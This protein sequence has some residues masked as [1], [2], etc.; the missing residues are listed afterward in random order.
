MKLFVAN[1]K[2]N[3]TLLEIEEYI[4]RLED[5]NTNNVKLVICPSYPYL[6]LFNGNNYQLGSQNVAE[7]EE[8]ALTGEVS[9]K[10]LSFLKVK[11]VLIGHSERRELLKEDNNQI[12]KKIKQVLKTGM[13]PILC[14]GE[15]KEQRDLG[16]AQM[17]LKDQIEEI[18]ISL[19]SLEREKVILAYE[20]IWAIGTG[21]SATVEEIEEVTSLIYR[22]LENVYELKAKILY[23]GS[24]NKENISSLEKISSLDGYLVGGATLNPNKLKEMIEI[25]EEEYL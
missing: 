16:K 25:M 22:Y 14:I 12:K 5:I 2:M 23:G 11:Y 8:G 19:T 10:Q 13:T 15:T 9:A 24:V 18:F 3:L 1:H 21:S 6:P 7:E 4:K 17:I 20:P